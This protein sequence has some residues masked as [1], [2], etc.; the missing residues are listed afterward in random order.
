[1]DV[2]VKERSQYH[3]CLPIVVGLIG[4]AAIGL[5]CGRGSVPPG[6]ASELSVRNAVLVQH[7]LLTGNLEAV[8]SAR[9]KVPQTREYRLQIQWI[10][11][12][13]SKVSV[14]DRVVEFDNNAF[15]VNLDQQRTAVQ[16]SRRV[17]LQNRANGD[18]RLR[19]AEAVVERARIALAKAKLDA[20]VPESVRSR[21]DHRTFELAQSKADANYQK[22][23]SDLRS[24]TSSVEADILVSE[25]EHLRSQRELGIA[26]EALKALVLTAPRDGIVVV[27]ENPREDRKYQA[28]DTVF[29][30]WSVVGI[31]DLDRL[32]VRASLSD[33]D[34]GHLEVGMTARCTPDIEP[35]LHLGGTITE[36]T[37]LAREQR[38]LSERR[39]FDVTIDIE[40]DHGDV[41]LIPGMS[42]RVEVEIRGPA[43]LLVPRAALDLQ[44]NPLRAL[45]A[46]GSW[47][48][49][50]IGA[51]SPHECVVIRGLSDGERL[52]PVTVQPS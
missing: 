22:A 6:P 45:R 19:E 35:D 23:V 20:S 29:P 24:T 37:H 30:G 1:M 10:A 46:D 52:A 21:Y 17:L 18:A 25:E 36:I 4:G 40:D 11:P 38:N 3:S 50:E 32:R 42:V 8:T 5:G 34:D 2:V 44:S 13:G 12:D 43:T 33:V 14:G 51:C 39:G 49:I 15:T 41:L 48:E 9:V 26:E 7:R 31:P 27:E 28:G 16:R 47:A